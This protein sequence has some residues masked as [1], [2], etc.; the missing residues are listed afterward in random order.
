M[1]KFGKRN[2]ISK[3]MTDYNIC[4][5][6]L[7]GIGKTTLMKTV[8]EKL[9]GNDGYIILNMGKEDG[10]S[11]IDGAI[12]ENIENWKKFDEVTKDIIKNKATDYPD[13]K[14]IVIDTID[15]LF[16]IAEPEVIRMYNQEKMGERNF[17]QVTSI[18]AAYGGYGAGLEKACQIVLDKIWA[19]KSVGIAVW[20]CG[21]TKNKDI[22]DPLTD[23]TYTT[24]TANLSQ[25]YFNAIKT[26]MHI[27]GMAVIDRDIVT[28]ATGRKDI[29]NREVT[30]NKIVSE[31]RKIIFRDDNYGVDS[32]SRFQYI[33]D[34]IPLDADA[35]IKA[36]QDAIY[37]GEQTDKAAPVAPKV[38]ATAAAPKSEPVKGTAPAPAPVK[39][40]EPAADDDN[41]DNLFGE[42][43]PVE[44]AP[45][46]E[47]PLEQLR[48]QARQ[49]IKGMTDD[50]L[51]S[52][53]RNIVLKYG[54]LANVDR[55]GLNEIIA[56]V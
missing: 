29:N 37:M 2:T 31:A 13:L 34:E 11:C 53:A 18:N 38:A 44:P 5:L 45:S 55:A 50:A 14:I 25:K 43:K 10:I 24:I 9:T 41:L 19:L 49:I 8:C 32:K 15:Q 33:V 40:P 7:P 23:Q 56:L 16:D 35:F 39:E 17:K 22:V 3:S 51:K 36:V 52:A 30:R 46:A 27:V 42:F 6:G 20:M 54:K 12:Y 1:G 4:I 48:E 28:E 21:H 47:V 26:K